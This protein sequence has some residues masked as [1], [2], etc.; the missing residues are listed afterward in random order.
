MRPVLNR[1]SIPPMPPSPN[2]ISRGRLISA[3][4]A[5]ALLAGTV[6]IAGTDPAD[7]AGDRDGGGALRQ[8]GE[9]EAPPYVTHAPGDCKVLFLVVLPGAIRGVRHGR[10]LAKP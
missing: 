7:A 5:V 2:P 8:G 4:V 1:Y 10:G 6:A 9:F 3:V